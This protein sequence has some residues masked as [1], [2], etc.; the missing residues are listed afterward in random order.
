M[1]QEEGVVPEMITDR[2]DATESPN[3]VPKAMLQ[4]ETGAFYESFDEGLIQ[5]ETLGYNT[6]LLRYGVLDNFEVRLGWNFE[7]IRTKIDTIQ[8][9]NVLSGFSPLL[10]GMKVEIAEENGWLPE[11]GLLGHLFLPFTAGDDFRPE[12]T[13]VDFRFSMAHTLSDR[14]G[15]AYNIGAQWGNDSPE[16]AYVYTLVYGYQLTEKM[17]LYAELYGDLPEDSRANHYWDAGLTFLVAPNFQL[18]ATVGRSITSGQD[19]LLSAG[20]SMR[21]PK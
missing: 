7:E 6:T 5:T 16:A 1:C 2:P 14:A 10:L 15:L 20:L 18:D 21:L 19:I 13:G 4:I 3:T 17:G 11:I 9:R 12:T 8:H